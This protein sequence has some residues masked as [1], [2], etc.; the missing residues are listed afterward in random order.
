MSAI[1]LELI[2][3]LDAIER[4]GSFASAAEELHRVPSALSYTIQ[5]YEESLG[6]NIFVRQGRRSVFT[7]SGRMLL[8]QGRDLLKRASLLAEGA[9]TLSSGW[10]SRLDIAVDSLLSFDLVMPV[11]SGFLKEHPSIE[12]D[13][14]EEVLGGTWEALIED[15]VQLVIGAPDPK[16]AISGIRTEVLGA[17]ERVFAVTP[18][19]P[20]AT[21]KEPLSTAEVA[22]HR[23]VVVHDSSR[24]QVPRNTRLLNE[25]KHFYVGNIYQKIAAQ[26]AGIGAGFLPRSLIK[27][28]LEAGLLVALRVEEVALQDQLYL[29]WKVNNRG[30]GLKRLIQMLLKSSVIQ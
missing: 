5:K 9:R 22:S 24:S 25:D 4:R 8:E 21:A 28:E 30:Q 12:M 11:F 20:L 16:P 18:N 27:K 26:K 14:H 7:P 10:E 1:S 17:V 19:H 3:I 6:F 29:A 2:E 13:I 23:L 15:R